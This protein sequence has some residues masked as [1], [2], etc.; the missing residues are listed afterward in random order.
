VKMLLRLALAAA[1]LAAVIGA[2]G[3]RSTTSNLDVQDNSAFIPT[4]RIAVDFNERPGPPSHLH[5]SHAVEVGVTG[6]TG[7]DTMQLSAGQQPVV[8]GGETFATPQDLKAQF[9]FRYTEVAY[10]YRYVSQRRGIGFEALAGAAYARLGLRLTGATRIAAEKLD[11]GGVVVGL[12]T[13]LR[14]WPSGS[15]QLRG[16][17]FFSNTSEGVSSV[18]RYEI[19]LEQALGRHAAIRAGYAGYDIRSQRENDGFSSSNRSPIRVRASGPTVGLMLM[20]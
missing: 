17:G 1:V 7:S 15:I 5:T 11:G 6:A 9:D 4:V 16:S 3:C 19:N 2:A 13:M 20:F 14:V 10:R 8:F 12:G 18:G